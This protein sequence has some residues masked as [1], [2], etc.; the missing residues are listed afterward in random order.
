MRATALIFSPAPVTACAALIKRQRSCQG[1]AG[2]GS[3]TNASD[4]IDDV[5]L[6]L[7]PSGWLG[8][9]IR[10]KTRERKAPY[11]TACL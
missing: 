11:Q 3:Q 1:L 7:R 6:G 4:A 9:E 5:K 8:R 2:Y 10:T